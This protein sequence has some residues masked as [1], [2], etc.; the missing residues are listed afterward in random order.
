MFEYCSHIVTQFA[1]SETFVF[2]SLTNVLNNARQYY[3]FK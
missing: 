3:F 2:C 1:N